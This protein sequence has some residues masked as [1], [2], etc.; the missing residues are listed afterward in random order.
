MDQ[1]RSRSP[2]SRILHNVNESAHNLFR[3]QGNAK[4]NAPASV[5]AISSHSSLRVQP[6]TT[7][8]DPAV[9]ITPA[10]IPT[11]PSSG[12]GTLASTAPSAP[13]VTPPSMIPSST[14]T[15]T[16]VAGVVPMSGAQSSSPAPILPVYIQS[17]AATGSNPFAPPPNRGQ[18]ATKW[19]FNKAIMGLGDQ[20][21]EVIQVHKLNQTGGS[22]LDVL[23]KAN[24]KRDEFLARAW[25]IPFGKR[26]INLRSAAQK[27][28]TLLNR[29]KSVG[30]IASAADPIH[31]GLP[32][33]A[34]R[35]LIDVSS[36]NTVSLLEFSSPSPF[37]SH[38]EILVLSY[39]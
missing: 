21:R 14:H 27:F 15:P 35:L 38:Y 34:V 6:G 20:E 37:C 16:T 29:F 36:I 1:N 18:E 25:N 39:S 28:I 2:F 31:A 32:W 4:T 17:T 5:T 11:I 9:A 26:T 8:S 22:F 12:S 10:T 24:L 19:I 23:T 7:S 33:A 13:P 3:S 30:D